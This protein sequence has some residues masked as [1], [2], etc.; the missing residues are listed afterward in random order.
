MSVC[1][2]TADNPKHLWTSVS[3][4]VCMLSRS[5]VYRYDVGSS[6]GGL[7]SSTT[8]CA[9]A[10]LQSPDVVGSPQ[11]RDFSR[12]CTGL[13]GPTFRNSSGRA[14]GHRVCFP[15]DLS[16]PAFRPS[17]PHDPAT[18]NHSCHTCQSATCQSSPASLHLPPNSKMKVTASFALIAALGLT[19]ASEFKV[20]SALSVETLLGETD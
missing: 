6:S 1:L 8:I 19:E 3:L 16:Q 18:P 5:L 11:P 15:S 7:L 17:R 12:T 9:S 20:G 2:P 13:R 4:Y 14:S 10:D